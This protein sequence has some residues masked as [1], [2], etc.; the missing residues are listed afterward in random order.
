[1]KKLATVFMMVLALNFLGV[2]GGVGWLW[3]AKHLDRDKVKSIREI[4]FPPPATAPATQPAVLADSTTQPTL[5]LEALLAKE[6]GH[7]ATEQVEFIQRTFDAQMAQLDR[8][9][10]ELEDLKQQ[11]DLA[12]EQ[13]TRDRAAMETERQALDTAKQ[14]QAALASDK[15]FQDSLSLYNTMA[16]K[17]VK[18]I[19][20][21]LDDPT[22]MNYLRAMQP[23]TAAKIIKEFKT[24]D[25]TD[26]IQRILERLRQSSP[27]TAPTPSGATAAAAP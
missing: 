11:T 21:G 4:L 16:P 2:A 1:M 24:Q 15:G 17:Q 5:R 25:E 18:S 3:S 26:R 27:T 7:S 22:I 20:M 9:E 14:Q 12:Q 13:L 19:F 23:R 8:R 6:S 10:R